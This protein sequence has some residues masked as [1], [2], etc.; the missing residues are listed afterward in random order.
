MGTVGAPA[1]SPHWDKTG[2]R[3]HSLD[4]RTDFRKVI[5][6][7]AAFMGYMRVGE[8]GDIGDG[9]ITD[10]EIVFRQMSFHHFERGPAAVTTNG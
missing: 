5:E 2:L 1:L 8:E 10:E 4:P 3:F 7:E 9:V 6:R